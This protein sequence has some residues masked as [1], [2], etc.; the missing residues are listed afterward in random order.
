MIQLP[1]SKSRKK[2]LIIPLLVVQTISADWNLRE[3][4][5]GS[6]TRPQTPNTQCC[7]M[8]PRKQQLLLGPSRLSD[9]SP[10]SL[11]AA[12]IRC[13]GAILQS[14]MRPSRAKSNNCSNFA[15][16]FGPQIFMGARCS[17]SVY[18]SERIAGIRGG[19]DPSLIVL[20][21][22]N[23]QITEV[24]AKI[25]WLCARRIHSQGRAGANHKGALR[26]IR[27]PLVVAWC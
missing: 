26:T 14:G 9:V 10:A 25:N 6:R 21:H 12:G 23:N 7:G 5:N 27:V 8:M 22:H 2:S 4:D 13:I 17:V 24:A 16:R 1:F 19:N 18:Y 15:G 11:R 3:G 20:Y